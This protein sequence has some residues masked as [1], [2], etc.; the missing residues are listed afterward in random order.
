[1]SHFKK[2]NL[3]K[4]IT[5]FYPKFNQIAKNIEGWYFFY[6]KIHIFLLPNL[7]KST[8][9]RLPLEQHQKIEKNQNSSYHHSFEKKD[10]NH[11]GLLVPDQ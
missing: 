7:I 9:E 3:V 10:P 11:V 2:I 1:L 8:Y 5:K 6:K 4:E